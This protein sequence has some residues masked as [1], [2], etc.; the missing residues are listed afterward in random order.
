MRKATLMSVCLNS[1]VMK[2]V[3]LPVYVKVA[4]L[5]F[6]GWSSDRGRGWGLAEVSGSRCC[7]GYY[8]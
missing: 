7:V 3:S 6:A 2:V 5:S 1:F 4:H 8:G